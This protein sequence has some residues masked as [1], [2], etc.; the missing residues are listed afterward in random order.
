MADQF[1][2][3]RTGL[4]RIQNHPMSKRKATTQKTSKSTKRRKT[5]G[6]SVIANTFGAP[7]KIGNEKKDFSFFVA[8]TIVAAQTTAVRTSLYS[9]DQGVGPSEHIGRA[10]SNHSLLWKWYGSY[11]AT[12]AGSSPIRLVIVYDRQPNAALPTTTDVFDQD[13]IG[14]LNNLNNNRRFLVLVNKEL[15]L[16]SAGPTAFNESGYVSFKKRYGAVLPTE[17]NTVNGGTIA[18]ITTGSFV[19]FTWQNGNIITANPTSALVTRIRYT[20]N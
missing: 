6:P 1:L 3:T 8:N 12:T 15:S 11:A 16:S 20:D 10:V 9:P 18:D 7:A 2:V 19:A 5:A 14:A 13:Y 4:I 17:F